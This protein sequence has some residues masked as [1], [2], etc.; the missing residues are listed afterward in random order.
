MIKACVFC[1]H[2]RYDP[3]QAYES[4]FIEAEFDC[5]KGKFIGKEDDFMGTGECYELA[6]NCQEFELKNDVKKYLARKS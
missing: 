5:D 4:C 2:C 3:P 6:K 1:K